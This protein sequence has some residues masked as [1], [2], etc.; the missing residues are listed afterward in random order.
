MADQIRQ[1]L[2]ENSYEFENQFMSVKF[3][4]GLPRP[5]WEL[6]VCVEDVIDVAIAKL[7]TY[8][9][10]SLACSENLEAIQAL[11]AAKDALKRRRQR[12]MLQGVFNTMAPHVER[13]K[14]F[15]TN[16]LPRCLRIR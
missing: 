13:T 4:Q 2:K 16:F 1:A 6:M 8:Q 5:T 12:R 10:G 7:E 9:D 14:T 11:Q 3:Q 15:W